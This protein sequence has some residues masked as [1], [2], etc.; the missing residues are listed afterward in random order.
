MR[1][2]YG[3]AL[4]FTEQSLDTGVKCSEL[5]DELES[6]FNEEEIGEFA[7]ELCTVLL[8]K[9]EGE[10]FDKLR[11]V[12]E[13]EGVLGYGKLY[14]WFT[15]VSGLGL[16]EQTRKLIHPDPPKREEGLS[17]YIE[18]WCERIRRLEAHGESYKLAPIF[19]ITAPK[20]MLVGKAK[21]HFEIW[22]G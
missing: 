19:K 6:K 11:P 2:S 13:R 5:Q 21:G 1:E 7:R 8:E 14:Q 22:Q 17:E 16:A 4:K 12:P 9:S 3:D 18:N 10:A 15:E 20:Q